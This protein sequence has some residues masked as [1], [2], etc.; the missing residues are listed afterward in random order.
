MSSK[1]KN[2]VIITG[3]TGFIGQHLTPLFLRANYDILAIVRDE[4]K[5]KS[6]VGLKM[7]SLYLQT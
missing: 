2:K 6:L 4:E 7:S 3:A 5:A 1:L